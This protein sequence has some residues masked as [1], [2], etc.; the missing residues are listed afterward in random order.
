MAE[1][2]IFLAQIYKVQNMASGGF[3]LTLD[4]SSQEA[5]AA[6]ELL[7]LSDKTGLLLSVTLKEDD[8]EPTI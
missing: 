7:K 8:G 3:R 1:D 5:E 2:V 4:I 6:A